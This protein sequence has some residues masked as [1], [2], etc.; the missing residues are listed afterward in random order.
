[1]F[2]YT[3][4]FGQ[5]NSNLLIKQLDTIDFGKKADS[6]IQTFCIQAYINYN[7]KDIAYC[8]LISAKHLLNH[9]DYKT[10]LD[11]INLAIKLY[12]KDKNKLFESYL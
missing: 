6:L 3:I 8:N 4:G 10:A 12:Q 1:M 5:N 9:S 11:K 2:A 7:Q